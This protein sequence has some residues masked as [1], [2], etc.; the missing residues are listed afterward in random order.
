MDSKKG[1]VVKTILQALLLAGAIAIAS[2]SP[3]FGVRLAR[4]LMRSVTRRK[5]IID[6]NKEKFRSAFYYLNGKGLIATEYK[7]GQMYIYLTE[8]GRK[9]AGRYQ[10]DD[11]EIKKTKSW[12]K[13][14]RILIFDI[15]DKH[16]IKRE[17]LRGKL[18][19]LGLFQLQKSVWVCPYNFKNE[20]KILRDFFGL[21]NAEMKIIVSN[22]IEDD[23]SIRAFFGLD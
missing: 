13:K 7:G 23:K 14:W 8:E 15:Q 1:E 5:K 2:T 3:Y 20:I 6:R 21:T 19:D 17:A 22:E 12:D 4:S 18:K 16:K 10:I 11:L 9:R